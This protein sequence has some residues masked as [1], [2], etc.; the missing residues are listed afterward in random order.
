M[1]RR[2]NSRGMFGCADAFRWRLDLDRSLLLT[3]LLGAGA[4]EAL[5]ILGD[6]MKRGL[7]DEGYDKAAIAD[8]IERAHKAAR[9]SGRG[10]HH[11]H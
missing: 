7:Y 6:S 8:R 9:E 3:L 11:H 10:H 5:E 1:V 2:N 4:G